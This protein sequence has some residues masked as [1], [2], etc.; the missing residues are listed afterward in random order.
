MSR[1]VASQRAWLAPSWVREDLSRKAQAL[2]SLD[3][4]FAESKSL[5]DAASGQSLV[6]FT[7]ASSGTYVGSDG[8]LKTATTNLLLRSEE[9]DNASWNKTGLLAFG[10]GSIIDVAVAPNGYITADKITENTST[11]VHSVSQ[12][13]AGTISVTAYTFSF[14]AKNAGRTVLSVWFRGANSA[15]RYEI[16]FNLA[17]GATRGG[18]LQGNFTSGSASITNVGNDWYR[19]TVTATPAAGETSLIGVV[20]INENTSTNISNAS[21]T[22]D[23]TSGIYLWGAQLEQSST[24]GEYIPTTS[25]INSA[26][27]FDHNPTTGESLG[28]LVEEQR[29]NSIRNNTMVGAVAGTPGTA[30]TNWTITSSATG[31]TREIIGTGTESG[32]TYIDVKYSGT[33]TSAGSLQISADTTTGIPALT[34]QTWTGSFY[35]RLV[36]GSLP[37]SA[38]WVWLERDSGGAIVVSGSGGSVPITADP[39]NSQRRSTTRTLSGGATVAN[40]SLRIDVTVPN[41]TA[42]DI[43]LRIGLPQLEQGAFATS[44][45]PTSGTTATRSADVASITGANFS[46]WYRQ[47]EGTVFADAAGVNNVG[48]ATRR[49]CEIRDNTSTDRLILGYSATN[50]NRFL[51]VDDGATVADISTTSTP[52]AKAIGAYKVNSFQLASNGLLGTED[53]VGTV[54]TPNQMFIGSQEGGTAATFLNGTIRRL[55]YWPARLANS[56]LQQITQ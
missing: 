42:V 14:Y 11:S 53:G 47:D 31:L 6:T 27:R 13:Y 16:G 33:S 36:G 45:I 34:G 43:T 41:T 20:Y 35:V 48:G 26:P 7:R 22:G 51:V 56:T 21:Y 9:F 54:P 46:S 1:L 28:L 39:L 19:C 55:T 4:R 2:P 5:T 23:G 17:T 49:Y 38:S 12:T 25:T 30:P 24:V 40:L 18:A 15:N 10:S 32:I 29:T 44:V 3:L 50:N 37:S 8:L 52:I